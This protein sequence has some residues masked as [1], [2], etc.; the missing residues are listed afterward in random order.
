MRWL[1][2][3]SPSLGRNCL[4]KKIIRVVETLFLNERTVLEDGAEP[5]G[6]T[7]VNEP[8]DIEIRG[9]VLTSPT[10]FCRQLLP[11]SRHWGQ[12]SDSYEGNAMKWHQGGTP[13][14]VRQ[15]EKHLECTRKKKQRLI[16][17]NCDPKCDSTNLK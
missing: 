9:R 5:I 11:L 1:A 3:C 15:Y 8:C 2:K 16:E 12:D 7:L 13:N 17:C 4:A 14:W 10:P 6:G